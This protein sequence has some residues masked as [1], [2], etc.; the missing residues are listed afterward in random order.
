MEVALHHF[1]YIFFIRKEIIKGQE[2]QEA[3][4]MGFIFES[5]VPQ[6]GGIMPECMR[7]H[8]INMMLLIGEVVP[9][10]WQMHLKVKIQLHHIREGKIDTD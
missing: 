7:L 2:Y 4:I 8:G 3:G 9:L 10:R 1:C 5:C 6:V